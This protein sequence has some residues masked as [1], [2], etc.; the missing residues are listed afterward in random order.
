M[1][2]APPIS[3]RRAARGTAR[4]GVPFYRTLA[5]SGVIALAHDVCGESAIF[6]I[7]EKVLIL[8]DRR[9]R[10]PLESLPSREEERPRDEEPEGSPIRKL[11]RKLKIS[12]WK[13]KTFHA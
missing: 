4:I 2:R 12:E 3:V 10:C 7:R 8:F 5:F 13:I 6:T 1:T 9:E 11:N